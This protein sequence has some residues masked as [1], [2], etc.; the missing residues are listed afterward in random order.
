MVSD[1]FCSSIPVNQTVRVICQ[2]LCTYLFICFSCV[3]K[4]MP[5]VLWRC[6]LGGRKGIR[7]V[8]NWV[9]GVLAWLSVWIE[10]QTCIWPSWCHCHSLSLASVKSIL[11]PA[12]QGNPGQRAV[13]L[14]Q[15]LPH[16]VA[17]QS[18]FLPN[19]FGVFIPSVLWRCFLGVRKSIRPVKTWVM[20]C[21]CCYQYTARCR[22][23]AYDPADATAIPKAPIVSCLI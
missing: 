3:A 21:W 4:Y 5:S 10:V 14:V 23:F 8:K 20:R 9:V 2:Y 19:Y 18:S 16:E 6:W 22:L 11:V 15:V 13:K 17:W 1:W 7:P 12:H